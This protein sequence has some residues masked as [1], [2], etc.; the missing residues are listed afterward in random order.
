M[1]LNCDSF[2]TGAVRSAAADECWVAI[3]SRVLFTPHPFGGQAASLRP[4]V[5]PGETGRL[6]S[7]LSRDK[8]R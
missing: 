1:V 6:R 2:L 7:R 4:F 3:S 5:L 8:R